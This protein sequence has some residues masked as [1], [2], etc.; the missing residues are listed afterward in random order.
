MFWYYLLKQHKRKKLRRKVSLEIMPFSFFKKLLYYFASTISVC[1]ELS[2]AMMVTDC[3]SKKNGL[4]LW[5]NDKKLWFLCF[6]LSIKSFIYLSFRVPTIIK[7]DW[8]W[9]YLALVISN[10]S[11]ALTKKRGTHHDI[12]SPL[13]IKTKGI[14]LPNATVAYILNCFIGQNNCFLNG[15]KSYGPLMIT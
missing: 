3:N 5:K 4:V 11:S 6:P 9:E 15:F 10:L 8:D 14:F 7:D 2:K 13:K 12:W 1:L